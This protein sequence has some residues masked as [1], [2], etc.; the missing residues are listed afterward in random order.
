MNSSAAITVFFRAMGGGPYRIDDAC[1]SLW[2]NTVTAATRGRRAGKGSDVR[3]ISLVKCTC[4]R[5]LILR[6]QYYYT[7][8]ARAVLGRQ[9][10][11]PLRRML[12]R[13]RGMV[14][15]S[16][17]GSLLSEAL[18]QREQGGRPVRP[19]YWRG[20]C[21]TDAGVI[22][23]DRQASG[24]QGSALAL[25]RSLCD[26]C[27]IEQECGLYALLGEPKPGAWGGM[28]GGMSI[29]QR[30]RVHMHVRTQEADDE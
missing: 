25:A 23:M 29:K 13:R 17:W 9:V 10:D 19:D 16:A 12:I 18:R 11:S 28:Y 1:E 27:P 14:S 2:H 3:V 20:V 8:N 26:S 6:A 4:P 7:K 24:E 15:V 22:I 30:E 21:R 5:A